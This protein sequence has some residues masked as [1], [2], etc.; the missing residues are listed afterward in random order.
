[1]RDAFGCIGKIFLDLQ[2]E[3]MIGSILEVFSGTRVDE[4]FEIVRDF[5]SKHSLE[6]VVGAIRK[7]FPRSKFMK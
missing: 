2:I 4:I 7:S 5:S 6:E 1:M 3:E